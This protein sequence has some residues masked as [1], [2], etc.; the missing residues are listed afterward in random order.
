[1]PT[2]TTRTFLDIVNRLSPSVPGCPTPVI[3]QYVRDAA[4]EACE[5][6]LAW[7]YEQPKIRLVPGA[8]D[9]AYEGPDDAEIHAFLTATVNGRALKP[10]TLEQL[11]D[12]YPKWPDQS[13]NER[14]E[15]MYITQLD[16]D[17]FSVAPIPDNS[18]TYDVRMIVCLKPLR[19]ATKMDKKF[20]DELENVIMHGAL[21]HLLVLPDRTWSD[22]E[23]AS[24]HAKQFAFKLSERRARTNLGAAKA[25]M[26]VQAQKFA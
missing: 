20:L 26:R 17:N 9:Y 18:T 24:Y 3:E 8:H 1:M 6:T 21:Q 11:Y 5:R 22:R 7:R 23:L 14:A 10:I 13:L 12:I 15:P 2:Y 16:P 25:S 4:I 19:T